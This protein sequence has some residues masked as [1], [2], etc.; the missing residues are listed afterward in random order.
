MSKIYLKQSTI[1]EYISHLSS[2]APDPQPITPPGVLPTRAAPAY[3]CSPF[4]KPIGA[5]SPT[6]RPSA[7]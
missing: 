2:P 5:G 6:A 7:E 4:S 1:T 3:Y